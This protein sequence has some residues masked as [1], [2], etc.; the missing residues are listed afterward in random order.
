[1]FTCILTL[2]L[3][4]GEPEQKE[5]GICLY[6]KREGKPVIELEKEKEEFK[7]EIKYLDEDE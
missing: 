1:M 5:K 2:S 7:I 6:G 4:M 3:M